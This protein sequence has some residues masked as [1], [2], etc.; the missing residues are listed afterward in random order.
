VRRLPTW[1]G[2]LNLTA[3][4]EGPAAVRVTLTGDLVVPP[5]GL[6]VRSPLAAPL[7]RA[8]VNG[9]PAGAVTSD[10]VTVAEF[11]AEVVLEY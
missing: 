10:G 9:R 5:G 2:I 3:R 6:V 1:Y 11:P 7:A 4:S 8:T